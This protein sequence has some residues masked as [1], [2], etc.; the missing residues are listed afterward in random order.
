[1]IV[2]VII[3]FQMKEENMNSEEY[4]RIIVNF[5]NDRYDKLYNNRFK[6]IHIYNYCVVNNNY[7]V[8]NEVLYNTINF[9]LNFLIDDGYLMRFKHTYMTLKKV[10]LDIIESN[11]CK[12]KR[13]EMRKYVT[14]NKK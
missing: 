14:N 12:N 13:L 6:K 2:G 1:M 5:V 11:E 4:I 3:V 7:N 8:D 9:V 10:D